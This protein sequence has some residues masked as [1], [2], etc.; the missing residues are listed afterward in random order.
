[1]VRSRCP[2]VLALVGHALELLARRLVDRQAHDVDREVDAGEGQRLG[3]GAGIAAGRLAVGDEH[4]GALAAAAPVGAGL[5][6]RLGDRRPA[7]GG[8]LADG[9]DELG[10]VAGGDVDGP[11]GVVAGLGGYR[12]GVH[13]GAEHAHADLRVGGQRV[14]ERGE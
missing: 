9:R 1:M 5:L 8:V 2:V 7:V 10:S 3:R 13:G 4:D 14:D 11:L 6:E 12:V